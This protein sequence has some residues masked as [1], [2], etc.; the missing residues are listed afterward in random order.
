SAF[1]QQ[2]SPIDADE[3]DLPLSD[4]EASI[5]GTQS[6]EYSESKVRSSQDTCADN[7]NVIVEGNSVAAEAAGTEQGERPALP[8]ETVAT[9]PHPSAAAPY[10]PRNYRFSRA[11]TSKSLEVPRIAKG[12]ADENGKGSLNRRVLQRAKREDVIYGVA[13]ASSAECKGPER[14]QALPRSLVSRLGFASTLAA[15]RRSDDLRFVIAPHPQ[16][17]EI[18]QVYDCEERTPVY[19]KISRSGRSWHETFHEVNAEEELAE[20]EAAKQHMYWRQQ[21]QQHYLQ[22]RHSSYVVGGGGSDVMAMSDYEM[23][24]AMGLPYPGLAAY[25]GRPMTFASAAAAS[26]VTIQSSVAGTSGYANGGMSNQSTVSF[27]LNSG[28]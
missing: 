24:S 12:T 13:S 8:L 26:C 27:M 17:A 5:V 16:F 4:S 18:A 22:Q 1:K 14:F 2:P 3:E 9:T 28:T 10:Q 19:R 20:L 25:G 11:V 23:A 15:R 6:R 7:D 21:Q